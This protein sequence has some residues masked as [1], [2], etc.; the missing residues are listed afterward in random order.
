MND[1][2]RLAGF[3]R[4]ALHGGPRDTG[5]IDDRELSADNPPPEWRRPREEAA[6][7]DEPA[8]AGPPDRPSYRAPSDPVAERIGAHI[9]RQLNAGQDPAWA[10]LGRAT[11]LEGR[12]LRLWAVNSTPETFELYARNVGLTVGDKPTDA[13]LS[14]SERSELVAARMAARMEAAG[15]HW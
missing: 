6:E 2:Q 11:G 4:D 12:E 8:D 13:D 5:P 10:A 9:D 15:K 3:L 1:D 14:P 7:S